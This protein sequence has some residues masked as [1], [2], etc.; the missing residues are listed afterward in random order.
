MRLL[1][2]RWEPVLRAIV[3][4]TQLKKHNADYRNSGRVAS[5]WRWMKPIKWRPFSV[6]TA[7]APRQIGHCMIGLLLPPHGSTRTFPLPVQ[8]EHFCSS[9][10]SS[11]SSLFT[12]ALLVRNTDS[13]FQAKLT[14]T[15]VSGHH[16]FWKTVITFASCLTNRDT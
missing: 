6:S 11:S 15:Q 12:I 9:I 4:K 13:K 2:H 14:I 16:G 1:D 10:G 3:G 7:P 5:K 8:R